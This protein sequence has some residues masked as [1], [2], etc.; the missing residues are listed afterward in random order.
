[1]ATPKKKKTGEGQYKKRFATLKEHRAAVAARKT[2][3]D[4]KNIGPVAHGASYANA[5]AASKK[6]ANPTPKASTPKASTP[7]KSTPKADPQRNTGSGRD[8]SF[9]LG[10]SGKGRT[11]DPKRPNQTVNGASLGSKLTPAEK[12]RREEA[13]ASVGRGRRT[14]TS[15]GGSRASNNNRGQLRANTSGPKVGSTRRIRKGRGYVTQMWNGKKYVTGKLGTKG[16]KG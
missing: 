15:R 1:M 7:K 5:L 12:K 13:A 16:A 4:G 11:S 10:T 2:L 9:G 6:K 8:G 3:K 14:G